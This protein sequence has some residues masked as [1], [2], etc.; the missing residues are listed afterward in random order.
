MKISTKLAGTA[1][2][3]ALSIGAVLPQVVKADDDSLTGKGKIQFTK[4]SSTST[5]QTNPSG[6]SNSGVITDSSAATSNS[7]NGEF[8]I[9][10][11]TNLDFEKHGVVT[12]NSSPNTYWAATWVGNTGAK[13]EQKN[14]NYIKFHDLRSTL[15]HSYE[16]S[17]EITKQF[18]DSSTPELKLNGSTITYTNAHL[19]PDVGYEPTLELD[20]TP[21]DGLQPGVV[22]KFGASRNYGY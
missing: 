8:G 15:D 18:T 14:A 6:G 7:A 17:G 21:N 4:S 5:T 2:I 12:S 1:L 9:D 16:I 11:V 19:I 13:D 20:L 22:L 10:F 3:T